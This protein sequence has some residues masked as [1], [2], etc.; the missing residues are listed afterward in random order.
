VPNLKPITLPEIRGGG[1]FDSIDPLDSRYYDDSAAK[2]LSERS[3]IAYQAY[4]ETALAHTL[5]DFKI[6]SRAVAN[7]IEKSARVVKIEDVYKE[8]EITKHDIKALV[9]CVK[10]PISNEAK[11]YVH[12]GATSYDII[13]TANALQMRDAIQQ[14][15]LPRLKELLAT[16]I[17][18]SED[19]AQSP[20]IGRTHGQHAVPITFGFA[21][22]EYVSRVGNTIITLNDLSRNLKGKF[23]GAVGA[24]NA[25]SIF[26]LMDSAS[27]RFYSIALASVASMA[28]RLNK[29][30]DKIEVDEEA[31]QRNLKLTGGAIAAEPL[32]LLFEKYGHIAAHEKAKELA[33]TALSKNLPLKDVIANDKE[34]VKYWQKFNQKERQIIIEP[35]KYYTGLAVK[36]ARRI[37]RLW[38]SRLNLG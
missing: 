17:K 7:E 10:K 1:N 19:Y 30:M 20:Q 3:R 9:N 16:L 21:L 8:E 18:L 37:N 26:D 25:L 38:K 14:L 35:E 5:A 33:H 12:F 11:P 32:Y 24:Y 28:S 4:I 15:V 2:Y 29:V 23:S 36:K 31:M 27:S 22:S 13:A 6:C 34:A